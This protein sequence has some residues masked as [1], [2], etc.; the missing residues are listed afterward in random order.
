M[1]APDEEHMTN[2]LLSCTSRLIPTTWLCYPNSAV[3]SRRDA[4][5]LQVRD[6]VMR[7]LNL[8]FLALAACL[9]TGCM[10]L[11]PSDAT[12]FIESSEVRVGY[13]KLYIFR[14]T[15]WR[16]GLINYIWPQVF[17]GERKIV[18][19]KDSAYTVLFVRPGRY[20][21]RTEKGQSPWPTPVERY[22]FTLTEAA[23]YFLLYDTDQDTWSITSGVYPVSPR[24]HLV[25]RNWALDQ[26]QKTY[27]IRP[28]I[29]A[30]DP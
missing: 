14:P 8:I 15:H 21:L 24:W 17:I 29:D 23:D 28:E 3:F 6:R 25:N 11:R 2:G 10:S 7:A 30:I 18:D 27:F 9:F 20:D 12:S 19:L 13:A 1:A 22:S 5:Y 4:G 16:G 26:L